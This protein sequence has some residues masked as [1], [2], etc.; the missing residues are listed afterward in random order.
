MIWESKDKESTHKAGAMERQNEPDP[1]K[2]KND[3][4]STTRTHLLV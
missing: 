3:S 2:G 1:A 4:T